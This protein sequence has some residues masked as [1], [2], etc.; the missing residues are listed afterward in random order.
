MQISHGGD[1]GGSDTGASDGGTGGKRGIV[2]VDDLGGPASMIGPSF[3][4]GYNVPPKTIEA[5]LVASNE[6][7]GVPGSV[8]GVGNE[9]GE[10]VPPPPKT[11]SNEGTGV[12]GSVV[13]EV[14]DK[15]GF[16]PA[17]A[18]RHEGTGVF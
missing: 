2:G 3:D 6:G 10:V 4:V 18:T 5:R 12:P 1:L 16:G 7:T 13:V 9:V 11:I 15:V 14:G 17:A 8:V